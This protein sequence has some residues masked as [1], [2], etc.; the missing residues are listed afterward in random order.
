MRIDGRGS[1]MYNNGAAYFFSFSRNVDDTLSPVVVVVQSA[2][3]RQK[4]S[5]SATRRGPTSRLDTSSSVI[6]ESMVFSRVQPA[7][8]LACSVKFGARH[9]SSGSTLY[10]NLNDIATAF[11]SKSRKIWRL[12][13][14][15]RVHGTG[16]SSSAEFQRITLL[17]RIR[18]C[19]NSMVDG[20]ERLL[21]AVWCTRH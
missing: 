1:P 11:C 14:V 16:S 3:R 18:F 4:P 8:N 9:R 2:W 10:G 17:F 19:R 7:S 21:S 12:N 6:R 5:T 13:S 15:P 20:V